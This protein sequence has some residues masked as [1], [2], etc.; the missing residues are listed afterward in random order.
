MEAYL[1]LIVALLCA[2]ILTLAITVSNAYDRLSLHQRQITNLQ[3][4]RDAVGSSLC[5]VKSQ[6]NDLCP[7]VK[8]L[9]EMTEV[10]E[11]KFNS[12]DAAVAKLEKLV[13]EGCS[14]RSNEQPQASPAETIDAMP[15]GPE[16]DAMIA[17]LFSKYR[18]WNVISLPQGVSTA[19]LSCDAS[20]AYDAAQGSTM[21]N[22]HER[23]KAVLG[24][25]LVLTS[26]QVSLCNA[27]G[28]P[29]APKA[30]RDHARKAFQES[31]TALENE[32]R[33]TPTSSPLY[34]LTPPNN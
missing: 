7:T 29:I 22:L 5:R 27:D 9:E 12:I 18:R 30:L 23:M 19:D 24:Q 15:P 32:V 33:R 25:Y 16:R 28:L 3:A 17:G 4:A 14:G 31:L 26:G 2:V 8:S 21:G 6:I 11:K 20:K 34:P 1:V 13:V 10:Y